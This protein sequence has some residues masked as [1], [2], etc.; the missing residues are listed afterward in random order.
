MAQALDEAIKISATLAALPAITARL[1]GG[2][3]I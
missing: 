3:A 2:G 1:A